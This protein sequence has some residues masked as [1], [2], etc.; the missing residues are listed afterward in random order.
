MIKI[1]K[2]WEISENLVTKKEH[3][4]N[5]RKF[6]KGMG[7]ATGVSLLPNW[8]LQAKAE[9]KNLDFQRN[10]QYQKDGVT[11]EKLFTTYNNFYEFGLDKQSVKTRA[12]N[13][14]NR[15]WSLEVGGLV[16]KPKTW[17]I[18]DIL[19]KMPLEERIY[20]FRCVETWSAVV[21]WVGF[22]LSK[23]LA[24]SE[25]HASAKYVE[26][27]TFFNPKFAPEQKN[28]FF[29]PWPYTEGLRLDEAK[30]EL[31]LLAVGLYGKELAPQNGAP[32]RLVVPWKYGFKSIKSIVSIKLTDKEPKTLWNELAPNEYGFFANVNPEVPHP[33][34]SQ[35]HD[36][37]LGNW[38]K[39]T[40]TQ[41]FNGYEK[42]VAGL[43][44]NLDLKKF[45]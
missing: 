41:K 19:K 22:E 44:K 33:R 26:F 38:V 32:I 1:K 37:P 36:K 2:D 17:D 29:Y 24:E 30:N 10:Q 27:K 9:L 43:Y 23:L 40:P 6:L 25:P 34:W 4:L 31:A 5:R 13:L 21:P 14:P 28:S 20:N 45:F 15:P 42:Q 11:A 18:E 35:A 3:F 16:K 7:A 8:A 39:R 12:K